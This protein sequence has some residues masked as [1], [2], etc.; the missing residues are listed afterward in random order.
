MLIIVFGLENPTFLTF[1]VVIWG[2]KFCIWYFVL[3][4]SRQIARWYCSLGQRKVSLNINGFNSKLYFQFWNQKIKRDPELH[5]QMCSKRFEKKC[6][7]LFWINS[8]YSYLK[9]KYVAEG[10]DEWLIYLSEVNSFSYKDM[11]HWTRTCLIS[12]AEFSFMQSQW[13]ELALRRV[14]DPNSIA[15]VTLCLNMENKWE[16]KMENIGVVKVI[17]TGQ[18]WYKI[19]TLTISDFLV[20]FLHISILVK[21]KKVK[22]LKNLSFSILI[23]CRLSRWMLLALVWKYSRMIIWLNYGLQ[24]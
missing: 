14:F 21:S 16:N 12:M 7:E 20:V 4:A 19:R 10:I 9:H 8:L 15:V 11:K 17:L 24:T 1:Q 6:P 23:Y 3:Q 5:F 18:I 22:T 13:G 2:P